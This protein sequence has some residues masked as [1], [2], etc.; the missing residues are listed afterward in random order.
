MHLAPE[1]K[2]HDPTP[3]KAKANVAEME[4][5]THWPACDVPLAASANRATDKE[6]AN[7]WH[8]RLGHIRMRDLQ[9][10][11]NTNKIT[12]IK[13]SAKMLA[14]HD[15]KKCQTCI[16]AKY[17]RSKLTKARTPTDV[18]MHTLHSD[19][20]GPF[21]VKTLA[22]GKY[23]IS[24]ICE[25]TSKGGVSITK[26]KDS[27]VDEMRRMILCWEAET[28]KKCQV[29]FTDRG[30]EYTNGLLKDWC[31]GRSIKH[32]YSQPRTPEI[33]G[34]A[35]RF[36][37][38]IT[39]ICRALLYNYKLTDSL[40]G[41]AMI[42]ACLIYNMSLNKKLNMTRHEAFYGTIPDV[43]NFRTFGCKVYAHVPHTARK[44]LEPKYQVGIFLGPELEG[45][46]YKILTYNDKLKRDKYQVRIVRDIVTFESLPKVTGVQDESQLHWGGHI[47]LPEGEEVAPEQ[48]ELEPLTGVPELQTPLESPGVVEVNSLDPPGVVGEGQRLALPQS[49]SDENYLQLALVDGP[50]HI[51]VRQAPHELVSD[52]VVAKQLTNLLDGVL[53]PEVGGDGRPQ[54]QNV[55][56]SQSP[57][58]QVG[59]DSP[60]VEPVVHD[61]VTPSS[62]D[63]EV[64][65]IIPAPA[66]VVADLQR[67]ARAVARAGPPARADARA[68]EKPTKQ[69]TVVK[70][71]TKVAVRSKT[72][73][74][75]VTFDLAE[76][77]PTRTLRSNTK[78]PTP[79]ESPV[80]K[81]QKPTP[82]PVGVPIPVLKPVGVL[83][84]TVKPVG[85]SNPTVRTVG[86]P[87]T[88]APVT[89]PIIRTIGTPVPRKPSTPLKSVLPSAKIK[90]ILR[91]GVGFLA[92][93]CGIELPR[94]FTFVTPTAFSVTAPY[95]PPDLGKYDIKQ[96]DKPDLVNGLMRH[97]DVE[98]QLSGP[99]PVMGD[100]TQINLPKTVKQAMA[101]P[102]AKEWAEATVEE[103]L[104]LVGNNT[105]T[106]VEKKPFMKVIPCKWVY[107]VKTDGNGKLD[108]FKARLVA[109][110]HRQIEGVDYNETYAHV[111]K[112]ATVRTLLSVAANRS[113][114]V[115]QLDI[116]TAF[117][118][119]TVDTDVYMLQPPGFVDGVQ[120]VVRV[121]KS[122]YGLKQAPRIWY[123]LLNKT[124]EGLGFVP[125]SA[126]SSFWVKEDGHNTVYL[127]SVVDDM[128]V[129]S[130]DP[131]LTKSILKQILKAF[132]G[133]S[134][135]RAHYYN[136]LKITWLDDEHAVILSQPKHIR[137]MIDKF[138]LIADL[139]TERMVPVEC[140]T[141]LCKVGVVGQD[142]SP[143]LDTA[144]YK[145][146]ELIGG[147]SYVACGSRPDICFIVN[148]LARYANAPRV[149]HWN[150]AIHVLQYLKHTINWGISLGQGS[151]FGDIL[152]HCEPERD[153]KIKGVKRKTPEPDVIAY[154]DANHGTSIDDK[155]SVSGV[156][157]QVFGGPV[158]WSSKVQAV[159][160]LST[161]ESE[162]RA[163]ST[164]AREALWLTKIVNLFKVPHVPFCIRGDNKGAIATVTNYMHTKN[165]KHI[166]I[167]L[168]FMRDYYRKGV[169]NFVHIDGK[170]NPADMFTKAV[171]KTQFESFRQVI[172]MRPVLESMG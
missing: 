47:D 84:P 130:D 37:Q 91:H 120:N 45:P 79:V 27:A 40:W 157:L 71:S 18:P 141:R 73:R 6:S 29:L 138:C 50:G 9:N 152:V 143:L 23:M 49:E 80:T 58:Q 145:Y 67:T 123:E 42:Y 12:G 10:L 136:G 83:K 88:T 61:P 19:I 131:A 39:N 65:A 78:T 76:Q 134:G 171:S 116:K 52:P 113:W 16:M 44:K 2:F 89:K 31:L 122:I 121:D 74:K 111:T 117:L 64:P 53:D 93:S 108:R 68:G 36:N 13:I 41:H 43:T 169:I 99:I 56:S 90:G 15:S 69:K 125:M 156:L 109:G 100:P 81:K 8:Q 86:T 107:T 102:F 1:F 20:Q 106:L 14:K 132:P 154:A 94:G 160:A 161:C 164:A 85:V 119:G 144:I 35:E 118:H 3:L 166:E 59:V 21:H 95:D 127:T 38:T 159:T 146:R 5:F 110:G 82:K 129:T 148:Q 165:T 126:D 63:K 28:Q 112:H 11:V 66:K 170:T 137:A 32:H 163:M 72:Q 105:W 48:A 139:V 133:T 114:D 128:L 87:L 103:W 17:R 62:L 98:G 46:G 97:F 77:P 22:G 150:L 101:S 75:K 142:E 104:S 158:I 7:L 115:Q 51:P 30:G 24:L 149:A 155:R 25:A 26:T 92:T 34:R 168:D 60:A 54:R 124:L 96:L 151:S 140:G 55:V 4:S 57:T 153:P 135:G 167:H 172:G 33:N 70:P 147:L 162:F